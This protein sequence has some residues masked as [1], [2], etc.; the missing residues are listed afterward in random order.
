VVFDEVPEAV[1]VLPVDF[2]AQQLSHRFEIVGRVPDGEVQVRGEPAG[3]VGVEL[4]ERGAALEDQMVE[5]P[6]L[7]QS[8]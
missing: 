8:C 4:A 2:A 5:Y 3:I 6:S 7:V 1:D